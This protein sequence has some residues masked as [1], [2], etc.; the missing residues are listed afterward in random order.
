MEMSACPGCGAVL[1]GPPTSADPRSG[2]SD[3]CRAVHA[4][5]AGYHWAGEVWSAWA[6]QH[7]AVADLI[8]DRLPLGTAR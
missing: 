5:V 3:A 4:E 8:R 2:A 6:E 7:D 1:P